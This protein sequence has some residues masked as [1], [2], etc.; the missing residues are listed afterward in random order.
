MQQR[1][2]HLS[3]CPKIIAFLN[4]SPPAP[5]VKTPLDFASGK[6]SVWLRLRQAGLVLLFMMTFSAAAQAALSNITNT[7]TSDGKGGIIIT[8]CTASGSGPLVIPGTI[9]SLNVTGFGSQA[10]TSV[11]AT[12]VTVPNSVTSIG[13][14]AFFFSTLTSISIPSSVTSIGQYAFYNCGNLTGVTV[15]SSVTSIGQYAFNS[16]IKLTSATFVMGLT[17]IGDYAFQSCSI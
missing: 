10:F 15:P 14:F 9:N 11:N 12:S 1:F 6:A 5:F 16:C 13:D 17:T 4:L 8:K 3:Y 2:L 7:T